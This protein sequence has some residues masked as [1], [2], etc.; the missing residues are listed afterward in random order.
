MNLLDIPGWI[1]ASFPNSRNM[2]QVAQKLDGII[3][4]IS[5]YV[6]ANFCSNHIKPEEARDPPHPC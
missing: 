4:A 6:E 5:P 3:G 2:K 1:K